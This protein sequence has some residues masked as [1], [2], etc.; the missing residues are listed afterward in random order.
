LPSNDERRERSPRTLRTIAAALCSA[1]CAAAIGC[2]PSASLLRPASGFTQALGRDHPLVGRVLVRGQLASEAQ[3]DTALTRASFLVLGES[4][5][6][7]DHH[8]LEAALL[9]RWLRSHAQARVAFEMLNETQAPALLPADNDPDLLAKRVA[10]SSSGWPDFALYRPVFSAAMQAGARI[11]A[12]HPS[13]EHV[14]ESMNGVP[15]SEA[16]ALHLDVPLPA[17]QT[18]AELDEIRASHCGFV[19]EP[20]LS[21]MQ[22]AQAYKDA[23]MARAL[24]RA[25]AP[26]VLV[27]GR[28]HARNDRGVPAFLARAG[29]A[30][31]LSIA[32][33]EVEAGHDQ[34]SDYDVSAFDLVVFT[35]RVSDEDPCLRFKEQLEQ[36]RKH[37]R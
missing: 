35:P 29:V 20:M 11:V 14:H 15:E 24:V 19:Q 22:H 23:F 26:G 32:L 6:N 8:L 5:D 36:M 27:T 25:G 33:L 30:S 37:T 28:G 31:T 2:S 21:A 4:H 18:Q 1:F 34:P 9:S 12:A 7:R 10:W 16:H 17:A 3:L 13:A